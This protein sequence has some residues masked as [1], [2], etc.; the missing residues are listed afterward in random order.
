MDYKLTIEEAGE[1]LQRVKENRTYDK[2][3]F[4]AE[5]ISSS[6]KVYISTYD[7]LEE[8]IKSGELPSEDAYALFITQIRNTLDSL[9][10][11]EHLITSKLESK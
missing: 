9:T 7:Y 4:M 6:G 1:L 10:R 3:R 2:Y 8:K 11:I 5:Q